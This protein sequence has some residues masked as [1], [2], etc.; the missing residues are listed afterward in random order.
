MAVS[1]LIGGKA[2]K[3]PLAQLI[4]DLGLPP[5]AQGIAIRYREGAVLD[6]FVLDRADRDEAETLSALG[7]PLLRTDILIPTPD[8]SAV[9]S[10]EVLGFARGLRERRIGG[11]G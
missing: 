1:P 5:G 8:R 11:G 6:G 2:V 9:L 3:G 4:R 7:L 10:H